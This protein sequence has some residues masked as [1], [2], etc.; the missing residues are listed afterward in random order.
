MTSNVICD[1][2]QM[3]Q[4]ALDSVDGYKAIKNVV[5]IKNGHLLIDAKL[6]HEKLSVD[7]N[8][9]NVYI[10]GAGWCLNSN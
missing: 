3:Y 8:E 6:N 2:K 5:Q 4:V 9:K 7:L 10:I 1:L